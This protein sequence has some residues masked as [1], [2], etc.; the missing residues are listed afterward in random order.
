MGH[1]LEIIIIYH[2]NKT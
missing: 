1:R 2:L